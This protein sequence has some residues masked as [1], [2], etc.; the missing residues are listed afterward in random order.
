VRR[1][2]FAGW[3]RV[4][5]ALAVL[6]ALT[7]ALG[8]GVAAAGPL[9]QAATPAAAT[10][11]PA[12]DP[13]PSGIKLGSGSDLAGIAPG[14][15]A[16]DDFAAAAKSEPFALKLADVVNQNRLGVNFTWTLVAG[17]L[18]MFMQAGFALV[19][20]GFCRAKNA[21]HVMA[22]NFMVYVLGLTGYFICGFAFQNGGVGISGVPNLGGLGVLNKEITLSIGGIDW[23]LIGGKGFFLSDGTYDVAVAVMFLFQMVFMDT[24]ATIPTG[25]MAERWKWS[26]FCVYGF[27]VS[28]VIY[29]VF[30]NWAWGGGWLSQLGKIGLGQGYVDFAGSGVVHAVG[31]WTALAG[32]IV[33]GPRL[34]KYNKDGSVNPIPGHNLVIALLGCFILAFGWFGF[35]PGSTLGASGNG[36]LR[37]GLVAVATMLA[38]A[39]GAITAM[40]Y[41]WIR[42]KKPDPGMMGN[43]LLAGLVA[44]TAP[45]GHVSPLNAFVIGI[46]AGVLV[47]WAVPFFDRIRVDD[48]VGAISVHGVNGLWGQIAVGLFADGTMNYGGTTV[49]GLFYGDGSQLIAQL[50][51]AA[52]CFVWAFGISWIFFT[53]QKAV[54]GI[55]VSEADEIAGLDLPEMG[56]PGYA[57]DAEPYRGHFPIPAAPTPVPAGVA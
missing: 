17:F 49:T 29:P 51:G 15:L 34:G 14:T 36:S 12:P 40:F 23:G 27:F 41:T 47:C 13:D 26:A 24:T 4:A 31:G 16:A 38:S 42:S 32:A 21:A 11:P 33:L 2:R 19:E 37:I 28:T 39:S 52:V 20:T 44:I 46:V 43:G 56:M 30:A 18:V 3:R 22:M 10:P 8:V 6:Y 54:M 7:L 53:V 1:S 45:S 9:D 48:P 5:L 57:P 50:V 55:R 35:N 25:A